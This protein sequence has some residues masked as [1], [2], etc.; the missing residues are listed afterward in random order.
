MKSV[1]SL[2]AERHLPYLLD[3]VNRRMQH[4]LAALVDARA[5]PQ[6]RGSHF[7]ILSMI[8]AE[9]AR[10]SALAAYAQMT[11]PALGELVRH[12]EEHGY[13][14]VTADESDRRAVIV[15]LTARGRRA[16]A[17]AEKGI[18]QLHHRWAQEIGP[19]QLGAMLDALANLA[20]GSS[21]S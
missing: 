2:V 1:N 13:L 8:P 18:A 20:T 11:R 9:G 6:L 16:H 12:L 19:G 5:F 15:R 4:D 3:T 21:S 10:P 17:A 14:S 7:R